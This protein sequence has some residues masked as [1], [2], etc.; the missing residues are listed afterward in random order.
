MESKSQ[1]GICANSSFS[2]WGAYL[3]PNRKI[4]MPSKWFNDAGM[5]TD[6]FYFPTVIKLECGNTL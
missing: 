4:T 2:W 1:A 6:G 3:N 5:Y